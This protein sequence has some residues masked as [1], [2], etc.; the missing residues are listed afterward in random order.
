MAKLSRGIEWL[1]QNQ[2]IRPHKNQT[3]G[4]LPLPP[5]I[6]EGGPRVLKMPSGDVMV[7]PDGKRR[8]TD[9][10]QWATRR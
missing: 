9:G 10:L 4:N 6:A 7:I 5:E 8:T 2:K 3:V 1:L